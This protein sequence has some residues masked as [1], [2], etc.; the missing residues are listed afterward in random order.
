MA[1]G[2]IPKRNVPCAARRACGPI[3]VIN[4]GPF[5]GSSVCIDVTVPLP[6]SLLLPPAPNSFWGRGVSEKA[7]GGATS[8]VG[9]LLERQATSP[10]DDAGADS[11]PFVF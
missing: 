8:C 6:D 3:V 7:L 11:K 5:F 4:T 2:S 1:C 10:Q 9:C